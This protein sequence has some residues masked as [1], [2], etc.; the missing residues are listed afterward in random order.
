MARVRPASSVSS[1]SPALGVSEYRSIGVRCATDWARENTSHFVPSVAAEGLAAVGFRLED[2]SGALGGARR[3][4]RCL[5]SAKDPRMLNRR[6]VMPTGHSPNAR[7]SDSRAVSVSLRLLRVQS[8][9]LAAQWRVS[10]ADRSDRTQRRGSSSPGSNF[11]IIDDENWII[12][13]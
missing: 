7:G 5:Q 6:S 9:A 11:D 3:A 13:Q 8:S 2:M 12:F 10:I 4:F 1:R